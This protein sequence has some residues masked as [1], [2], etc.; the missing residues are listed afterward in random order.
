M[1]L[2]GEVEFLCA[3]IMEPSV[4]GC[5]EPAISVCPEAFDAAVEAGDAT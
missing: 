5:G 4:L 3:L 2:F 1:G